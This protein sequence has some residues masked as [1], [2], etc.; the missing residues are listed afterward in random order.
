MPPIRSESSQKLVN[1]EGK[2]LLALKILKMGAS[3]LFAQQLLY[4]QYHVYG[5]AKRSMQFMHSN[6]SIKGEERRKVVSS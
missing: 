4:T 2:M 3:N 1:Q 6:E 5:P